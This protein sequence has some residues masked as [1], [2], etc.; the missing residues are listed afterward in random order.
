[1]TDY[2][3]PLGA[4]IW[5]DLMSSDP[6]GAAE[7]YRSIF[8]WEVEG[9]PREEFGGYQNFMLHGHRVA[10][11]SPFMEGAGAPA[12]IWS[13]YL[14]TADAEATAAAAGEA[15]GTAIVPPMAVGDE[16]TML[17]VAD[18]AGAAIGFWQPNAHTG[19]A[20]WGVHGAPYWFDCL[21]KDYAASL[22]FYPPVTG[23]RLEEVG[24]GGD[25]NAQGPDFYSQV[26]NGDLS[27][28]GIMNA[29][30]ML[31]PEAPSFWQM[32][33]TVDDVAATVEKVTSLGGSVLMPADETPYGTLASLKDP[34]G[35]VFNLGHPPA[36][37]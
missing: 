16:G 13:V 33:V 21:S 24:S 27:Y 28:S 35:A 20:E 2:S 10:G 9:P 8:G 5:M 31:P 22:A 25:A 14:H 32:Y 12:D 23:A 30:T 4:P 37:M 7:F 29:S 34:Y 26:F 3:A 18:T 19:F 36:G 11:L 1:M 6:A 15:G 17:V